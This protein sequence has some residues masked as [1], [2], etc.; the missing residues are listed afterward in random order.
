MRLLTGKKSKKIRKHLRKIINAWNKKEVDK[1]NNA[2]K[3]LSET[4]CLG[5]VVIHHKLFSVLEF[6][7]RNCYASLRNLSAISRFTEKAISILVLLSLSQQS[8]LLRDSQ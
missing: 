7:D 8:F 1:I 3:R 4:N 5:Q 6:S 2:M